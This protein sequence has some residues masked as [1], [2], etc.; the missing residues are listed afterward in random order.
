TLNA[1]ADHFLRQF[2][3]A[4]TS[5]IFYE[6]SSSMERKREYM[7]VEVPAGQGVYVWVDY[8]ENGIM[9]LDEFEIAPYPDEANF[10]RVFVPTDD[11]IRTYST[12]ISQSINLEPSQLWRESTG[13]RQFLSRFSNRL[14]YRIDK[15]NQGGL[16]AENFNPFFTDVED[17]LL[18]TLNA[19]LRNSLFFNR[20]HRTWSI[21]WTIQEN[22]SKSILSNG[23]ES[24]VLSSQTWRTRW[25]IN[26]QISLHFTSLY[27]DRINESEFFERRN[28]RI[29]FYD[30]E[31]SL[32]IQPRQNLRFTVF[33]GYNSQQNKVGETGEKALI[34]K[35]GLETRV[36][37]P[38]R[39]NLQA[40]YQL[41][42][43]EYPFDV[44]SPV[45]FEMLQAL[46]PGTNNIWSINW[47]HNLSSYLQLNLN[48][49]GRK[50]PGVAAIHTGTVQLRA[51][52]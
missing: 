17:T 1:R 43:I 5:N 35:G 26:R 2:N 41:S 34:H 4:L 18:V 51:F 46:R 36:S 39:G 20:T 31:P 13:W 25:N 32:N 14:N 49:N 28:Y 40:R 16:L 44:N 8:N 48:Y 42:Q 24:R 11:F 27:G 19:T 38:S 23:F 6:A 3:G 9:E 21:E 47:Q 45:A 29:R 50:P 22:S 7:Y 52:F 15:K 30:L 12:A 37:F 10:I 33:Y